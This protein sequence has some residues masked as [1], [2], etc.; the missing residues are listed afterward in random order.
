MNQDEITMEECRASWR[1]EACVK[2]NLEAEE[3]G[4]VGMAALDFV[5]ERELEI[6]RELEKLGEENIR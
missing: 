5:T 4:L 1:A 3:H 6:Y 2:A